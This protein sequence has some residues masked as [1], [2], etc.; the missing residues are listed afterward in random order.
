MAHHAD[1]QP[2]QVAR[3]SH[4][5]D[6]QRCRMIGYE[7]ADPRRDNERR[8]QMSGQE[9]GNGRYDPTSTHAS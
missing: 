6:R 4:R 2:E 9:T 7:T 3:A 5:K 1:A 8:K